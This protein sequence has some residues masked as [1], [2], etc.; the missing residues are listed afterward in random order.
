MTHNP[1]CDSCFSLV[2]FCRFR[3]FLVFEIGIVL[4]AAGVVAVI[5]VVVVGGVWC[6]DAA[7]VVPFDW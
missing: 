4:V 1:L 5:V 6:D 2:F 7:H 3:V